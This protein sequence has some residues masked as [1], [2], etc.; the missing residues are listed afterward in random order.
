MSDDDA[1]SLDPLAEEALSWLVRLHSG[2]ETDEDWQRYHDWRAEKPEHLRAARQAE[3]MWSRLGP[4]LAKRNTRKILGA[5]VL[6]LTMAG[7]SAYLGAFGRPNAWL[8]DEATGIGEQR[9][10]K[11]ADGSEVMLDSVT[12]FDVVFSPH[13][14]RIVL[15]DG[16]VYVT[17]QPDP[18]R[19]FL[20]EAS[21]GTVQALGTA[22]NVRMEHDGA[23]VA[24]T[25][26]TV[27]VSYGAARSVDVSAGQGVDFE[28]GRGLGSVT[29]VDTASIT[30]W[31]HG[32][33]VFD[34]QP[35]G[36]VIEDLRRYERGAVVFTDPGLKDL[37]VTGV[38][39]TSDSDAFF[40]ALEAALPVR[41][42]RLPLVTVISRTK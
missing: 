34:N 40:N 10:V 38:F 30:S 32:E 33:V 18:K 37:G 6:A 22:F 20:V 11:L 35:L 9:L 31:R 19:R 7:A 8:A 4:A 14:R 21:G 36:S 17:V 26:H 13:E 39:A 29:A 15:R 16:Q 42:T 24:V 12:S 27:R 23:R 1:G 25:E 2:E 5:L 3:E 41:V 28:S